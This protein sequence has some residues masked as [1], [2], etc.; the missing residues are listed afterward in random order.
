M[1]EWSIKN[2]LDILWKGKNLIIIFIIL[3][4]ICGYVYNSVFTKP[5]YKS[6]SSI[7]LSVTG[8]SVEEVLTNDV[9]E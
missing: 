7:I 6:T 4:C 2:I 5:I 8:Q 9:D 1:K 3:G